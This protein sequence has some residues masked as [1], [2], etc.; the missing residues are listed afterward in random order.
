MFDIREP[1]SSLGD[2]MFS[3]DDSDPGAVPLERVEA[4]ICELAGHL[5]AANWARMTG[6]PRRARATRTCSRAVPEDSW[7]FHDS[8]CAQ[9]FISHDAQPRRASKSPSR[10]RNRQVAAA[11]CP[12]SSHALTQLDGCYKVAT[13]RLLCIGG[14][15]AFPA[16]P[17][18]TPLRHPPAV[19]PGR[20]GSSG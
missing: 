16:R 19:H 8:H 12:A 2:T 13:V 6:R 11:R 3:S 1:G 17:A 15:Y 5:A 20:T 18:P 9:L 10:T 7:H 4:E 14:R